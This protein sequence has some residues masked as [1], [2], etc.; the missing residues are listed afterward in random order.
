MANP[1]AA[2]STGL[3]RRR[4]FRV[5]VPEASQ[6]RVRVWRLAP[7]VTLATRPMPSQLLP[8]E[9]RQVSA[10]GMTIALRGK[11]G[12]PPRVTAA[13]RLRVEVQ[14]ADRTALVEAR[15][16]EPADRPTTD[17]EFHAG[18]RLH[19]R[20]TDHAH[21]EALATIATIVGQLQREALRARRAA[22]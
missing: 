13:D 22:A 8:V 16:R 2:A 10:E 19:G 21:R 7:G 11:D 14:Y 20:P 6:L 15:L 5:T 4:H 18:L 9:V 12:Q 17:A 1:T 3:E